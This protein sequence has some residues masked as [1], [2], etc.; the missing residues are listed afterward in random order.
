MLSVRIL[1]AEDVHMIR[2]ALIAL[3]ELEPDLEVVASVDRGDLIVE[4]ALRTGPDVAVIDIDLPG[5]DGITAAAELHER[6]PAC[7]A[8][9]LTNLGRPGTVRRALSAHVSGF[10]LKDAPPS[11]L[12]QAVRSVAAGQRVVD[13]Q[14]AL[15][16]W[17]ASDSPLSPRETQVLRMAARGADADEIAGTL[18]LTTGTVRNYLTAIVSKLNA[19]NR[20][21]AIRIA[22]E[23][24][25]IP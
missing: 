20:I 14:L 17:E 18:Y 21:D 3:L 23:A 8:L 7:R 5:S 19:R 13:P 16:A 25:W 4:T 12:A 1:L 24:G 11:Q 10:L 15:S 22:E 2:G 6:L 9:I